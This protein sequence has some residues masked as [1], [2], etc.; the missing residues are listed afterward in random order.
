MPP[1]TRRCPPRSVAHARAAAGVALRSCAEEQVRNVFRR[2][3]ARTGEVVS[4]RAGDVQNLPHAAQPGWAAAL[5]PVRP[6]NRRRPVVCHEVPLHHL[7]RVDDT[8]VLPDG[9]ILGQR[10]DSRPWCRATLRLLSVAGEPVG[11]GA[12]RSQLGRSL[13][14]PVTLPRP[15]PS[16]RST[17][18]GSAPWRHRRCGLGSS[19][20]LHFRLGWGILAVPDRVI[21]LEIGEILALF[22]RSRQLGRLPAQI[23]G[24]D[25]PT[26]PRAALRRS[27][28]GRA[29]RSSIG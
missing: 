14:G 10:P 18:R 21:G 4:L 16:A 12:G 24:P 9:G 8:R 22:V 13:K 27:S 1:S 6:V 3:P 20:G 19:R 26:R 11:L 17:G 23:S 28:F 25:R 15:R 29:L 7:V 5:R 2:G